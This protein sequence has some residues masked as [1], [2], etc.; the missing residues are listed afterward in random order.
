MPRLLAPVLAVSLASAYQLDTVI[1]VPMRA[2]SECAHGCAAWADLAGSHNTARQA[3]VD[4][5]WADAVAERGAGASCAI[6]ANWGVPQGAVCYCRGTA[7]APTSAWGICSEPDVPTP[8]QVNLQYGASGTELQ[9]AWVTADRGAPLVR[10]PLV[11]LCAEGAPCVNVSGASTRAPEPQLPSRVL[12]FS[13]VPLPAAATAAGAR[14]TYRALPGTAAAAWS[15]VF[16]VATPAAGATQTLAIFGDQGLYPYSSVGNLIDDAKRGWAA[17][18]IQGVVHLGDLAYNMAM[19]NGTRGD[20]YMYALE[21]LL[22]SVPWLSAEGNHELEGSPSI[23]P[24]L[25]PPSLLPHPPV[26]LPLPQGSPFGVYCPLAE[27]CESRYLKQ[28][29]GYLVAG[30]ASGSGTNRYFSLDVGLLHVVVFNT[31]NY[32][33]LGENVRAKQLA[34]LEE[35]LR[36]ASAPEQRARVPWILVAS[37]SPCA[38]PPPSSHPLSPTPH[39]RSLA[40]LPFAAHVPMY[41]SAVGQTGVGGDSR[42][43]IEPLLLSA[44]VDL[45]MYGHVHSYEA[46]WPVGPDGAVAAQSYI[47]PRAPVHVLTG[48]GGPPGS[49][50]T[51]P[52]TRPV[53]SRA[54]YSSWSFG[55]LQV[56]NATHLTFSQLDNVAGAVVDSF[57]IVQEGRAKRFQ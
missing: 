19:S 50:D 3:A 55:R 39:L 41:C 29:A 10:A 11:E 36:K 43:D 18:G 52:A 5:L 57:T 38:P 54:N 15:R 26:S 37:A 8:Q 33:G 27:D 17:G 23:S 53:W 13:L 2:P 44:S 40:P 12:T 16:S 42:A 31:M 6:P 45:Y 35:D 34:W 30:R 22:S 46:T 4:A 25:S 1:P 48:A 28:I 56:F 20:A 49:P 32:L 47:N 14:F 21:P 7:S 9:V 24:S 51:Y